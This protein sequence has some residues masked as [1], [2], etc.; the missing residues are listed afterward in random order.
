M[1][2]R[3][4]NMPELIFEVMD[5]TNLNYKDE[6]FNFIIDKSTLDAIL[7]GNESFLNAAKY[8]KEA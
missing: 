6:F 3:A 1:Q 5:C 4:I 2:S 7:C 8:L